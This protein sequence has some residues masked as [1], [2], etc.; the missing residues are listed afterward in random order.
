[1]A[2]GGH[3]LAGVDIR[4]ASKF[5]IDVRGRWHDGT[6]KVTTLE[7]DINRADREFKMQQDVAQYS[8]GV[9][10]YFR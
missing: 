6:G 7:S 4:I 3:L 5:W 2:V 8:V 9:I 10:Y 1:M